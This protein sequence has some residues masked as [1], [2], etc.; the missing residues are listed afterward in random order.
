MTP[1][2]PTA[3]I[4]LLGWGGESNAILAVR[5]E[6]VAT[7][8]V[9]QTY[10]AGEE[11]AGWG[12]PFATDA[13]AL[14][15]QVQVPGQGLLHGHDIHAFLP[16]PV[17]NLTGPGPW[18]GLVMGMVLA[19]RK[20]GERPFIATGIVEQQDG[21]LRIV[22]GEPETLEQRL[23]A[24][25]S[26]LEQRSAPEDPIPICVPAALLDV[27][28]EEGVAAWRDGLARWGGRLERVDNLSTAIDRVTVGS[29]TPKPVP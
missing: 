2:G 12:V 16:Q 23:D 21:D 29:A 5:F 28:G 11:L 7:L 4:P 18:L 20:A 10:S 9:N 6:R 19:A 14:A 15:F 13:A 3:L 25:L 27:C 8:S 26:F 1:A 24:V 22:D 17:S